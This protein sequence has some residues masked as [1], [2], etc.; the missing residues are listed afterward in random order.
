LNFIVVYED[1][2]K[3]LSIARIIRGPEGERTKVVQLGCGITGLVCAEQLERNP[4]VDE[5]VLADAKT[6]AAEAMAARIKSGKISTVKVDG[7]NPRDLRR[8]LKGKNIVVSSMPWQLNRQVLDTA[9]DLG[10]DYVDFYLP[11]ESMEDFEKVRSE[12]R[13]AGIT[14]LTSTGEDPGI[15]DVFA[16]HGA[17]KLD[18]AEEA[19]VKD[20]DSG[21]A[22]GYDFFSLWS[23]IDL[24]E[25][26]TVPAAVF[27]NGKMTYVPPL[28]H[29]EVY[30]FPPPLGP[31][32]VYQTNHEETYLMPRFIKGIKHADF[33]IAIDDN[34]AKTAN[35]L[36]KMGL[37]SLKEVD[38]KGVKVKPL[39]VVVALLPRPVDLAGKV[40]GYACIMVEV[41]GL[42]GRERTKVKTWTMMSHEKAFELCGSNATGY[43]VGVG[44]AV[45]TEMLIAGEVREKGLVVPEQLPPEKFIARLPS[46]GLVVKQEIVRM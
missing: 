32:P 15:S 28:S 1:G 14:A 39:D 22:E 5:L 43:L 9:I 35:M 42:K 13:D 16:V 3:P 45:A 33:Q 24:L 31:L 2:W 41:V 12:C 19:H 7:T 11:V 44:G 23:P 34:F 36:R 46:K 18:V 25:E 37:H 10:I 38:V 17:S 26:V 27:K 20:G 40:K 30:D 21:V 29:R 4:K 6:D 8:L